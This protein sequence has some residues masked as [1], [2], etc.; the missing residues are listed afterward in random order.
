MLKKLY[1]ILLALLMAARPIIFTLSA[2]FI[3]FLMVLTVV[4]AVLFLGF[5]IFAVWQS[6][7]DLIFGK[8]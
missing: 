3:Y 1:S 8:I 2:L 4:G 5:A 6:F 7:L